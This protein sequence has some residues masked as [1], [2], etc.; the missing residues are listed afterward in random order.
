MLAVIQ[1]QFSTTVEQY[2]SLKQDKLKLFVVVGFLMIPLL[3][4]VSWIFVKQIQGECERAIKFF[5][6][7]PRSFITRIEISKQLHKS[8]IL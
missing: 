2:L 8:G 5:R 1:T 6:I 4:L 7:L 3:I